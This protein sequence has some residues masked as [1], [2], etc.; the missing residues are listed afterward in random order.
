MEE[1]KKFG[2]GVDIENISRF[3]K[4]D[5][6]KNHRFL[7]KLFSKKE[8]EY[9][10]SKE[11]AAPHLTARFAGKEA[12]LKALDSVCELNPGIRNIE[13]TNNELGVPI[14]KLNN[15]D[16]SN[17]IIKISL[18]HCEDKAIGFACVFWGDK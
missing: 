1:I 8:L 5:Y 14:V 18:S 7:D 12:V 15:V 17:L 6:K 2:V 11:N 4:L 9:C 16:S 3:R 10:F 13:I